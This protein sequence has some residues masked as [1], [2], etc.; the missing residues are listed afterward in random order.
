MLPPPLPSPPLPAPAGA[1]AS[2]TM[3]RRRS[4]C[5]CA[6]RPARAGGTDPAP[7]SNRSHCPGRRGSPAAARSIPRSRPGPP[8]GRG[9][10]V[11]VQMQPRNL[12]KQDGNVSARLSHRLRAQQIARRGTLP[13]R[14]DGGEFVIR[15][16]VHGAPHCVVTRPHRSP[17][18][19]G[20]HGGIG[21]AHTIAAYYRR[22]VDAGRGLFVAEHRAHR[23]QQACQSKGLL[24]HRAV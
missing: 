20:Y 1:R 7:P 11:E 24:Q 13:P 21:T 10:D 23:A 22:M 8:W 3:G 16:I 6:C 5:R 2:H 4:R 19:P 14:R 9:E 15:S 12:P 17:Y 18:P